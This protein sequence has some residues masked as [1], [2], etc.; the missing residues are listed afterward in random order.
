VLASTLTRVSKEDHHDWMRGVLGRTAIPFTLVIL[1]ATAT[2][3]AA[4][5]YCPTALRLA[6]LLHGR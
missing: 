3:W 6:D 1:F 4:H 2:G 5:R